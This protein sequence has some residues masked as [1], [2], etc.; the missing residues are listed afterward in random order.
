MGGTLTEDLTQGTIGLEYERR[1]WRRVGLVLAFEYVGGDLREYILAGGVILHPV[2]GLH[3]TLG[4]GLERR[5][6]HEDHEEE[7]AV[8]VASNEAGSST[9]SLFVA[10][11]GISYEIELGHRWSLTPQFN[12]DFVDGEVVEVF[13]A[14]V[15]FGF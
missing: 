9:E 4:G 14:S 13:G 2:G 11:L 6:A 7:Q 5:P 8:E 3:I 1:P 15:G 12:L 10:R